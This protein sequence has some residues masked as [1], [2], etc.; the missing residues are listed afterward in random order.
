M[1]ISYRFCSVFFVLDELGPN[2]NT[3]LKGV[4]VNKN[5]NL[6]ALAVIMVMF[7]CATTVNA[8]GV[9]YPAPQI[10]ASGGPEPYGSPT[11]MWVAGKVV[12]WDVLTATTHVTVRTKEKG[13]IEKLYFYGPISLSASEMVGTDR[14]FIV[15]K[16]MSPGDEHLVKKILVPGPVGLNGPIMVPTTVYEGRQLTAL[17]PVIILQADEIAIEGTVSA[18]ILGSDGLIGIVAQ[19]RDGTQAKVNGRLLIGVDEKDFVFIVNRSPG[20]NGERTII[21]ML[22]QV[23]R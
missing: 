13:V 11:E 7:V 14:V 1:L 8:Q 21:G 17:E 12:T 6:W 20:P 5:W 3:P 19:L 22:R 10:V 9:T 4:F 23:K 18:R 2:K 16:S 15:D